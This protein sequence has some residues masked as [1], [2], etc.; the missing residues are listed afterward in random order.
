MT[1]LPALIT[2]NQ[3]AAQVGVNR[4]TITKYVETGRLTPAM[5]L[6]GTKGAWLFR[7]ADIDLLAGERRRELE[8]KLATVADA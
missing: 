4:R 1:D 6:P 3:A 7:Q 8:A 5:K 2:A